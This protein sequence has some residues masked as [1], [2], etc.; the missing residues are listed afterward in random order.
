MSD[1]NDLF[2]GF[3][4]RADEVASAFRGSEV[5]FVIV[6]SPAPLAIEEAMFF[7]ARLREAGMKNDAFVINQ[8]HPLVAEPSANAATLEA[9]TRAKLAEAGVAGDVPRLEIGRA[10]CRERVWRYV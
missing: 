10:S 6:T 2:G 7:A 5:A 1:F 9:E 4:K 3:R 8:V